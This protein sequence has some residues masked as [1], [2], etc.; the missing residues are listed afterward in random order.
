MSLSGS[1]LDLSCHLTKPV[2]SAMVILRRLKISRGSAQTFIQ[3]SGSTRRGLLTNGIRQTQW[4]SQAKSEASRIS[5]PY[6]RPESNLK[7]CRRMQ[8]IGYKTEAR[9]ARPLSHPLL[10][11]WEHIS[12]L[13]GTLHQRKRS[14]RQLPS[15]SHRSVPVTLWEWIG[16][17]PAI[18]A[19]LGCTFGFRSILKPLE[20][21]NVVGQR[22]HA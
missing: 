1:A 5:V 17:S 7:D 18:A 4:N 9:P 21:Y 11:D 15:P 20:D 19:V 16:P 3:S 13:I 2:S 10:E 12:L 14:Q 6:L 8:V 22:Y